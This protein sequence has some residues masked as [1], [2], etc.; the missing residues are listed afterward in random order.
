[1]TDQLHHRPISDSNLAVHV[2]VPNGNVMTST[3]TMNLPLPHL[4]ASTTKS[5]AFP[6][7]ASSSLLSVGQICDN[8]CTAIFNSTSVHMYRNQDNT[9][10]PSQPPI[11]AGTRTIPFKP[12]YNIRMSPKAPPSYIGIHAAN[13]LTGKLRHL[14]DRMAFYHAALFS[15]VLSTWTHTISAGYLDSWPALTT[16]QVTQYAPRSKAMSLQHMHAQRS[17]IGST[18][19][20]A[21]VTNTQASSQRTNNIYAD[22]RAITS[23]I[24]SDQTGRF[25]VQSTSGNN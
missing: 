24:G 10:L 11:I 1:M 3:G 5:H 17:N 21:I 22:C 12:L 16:K 25:I 18:K 2:I 7:L 19:D 9:F 6:K 13:S 23:N 8:A 14:Q 20:T 4:K 15:P